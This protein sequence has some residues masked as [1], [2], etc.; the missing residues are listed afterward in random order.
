MI[1]SKLDT[2]SEELCVG[3]QCSAPCSYQ[4]WH[5]FGNPVYEF[6]QFLRIELRVPDIEIDVLGYTASAGEDFR[7]KDLQES[8][9]KQS[10]IAKGKL[11]DFVLNSNLCIGRV[12]SNV[13]LVHQAVATRSIAGRKTQQFFGIHWRRMS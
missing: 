12:T 10:A 4:G 11:F 8:G 13:L 2:I 5:A 3:I 9:Y 7:S 6:C 1:L